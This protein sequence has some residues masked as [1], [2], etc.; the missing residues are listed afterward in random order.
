MLAA[1]ASNTID[2]SKYE[3]QD[4]CNFVIRMY[5]QVLG[6]K[7][8]SEGL[9]HWYNKLVNKE[10]EGANLVDGFVSSDEFKNKPLSTTEFLDIMYSAILDRKPDAQGSQNWSEVLSYGVSRKYISAQFVG[11]DEFNRLCA[12]YNI[13]QGHI[14]LSENRDKNLT[15][16]KFV[17]YFYQNCLNRQ[18]DTNGL[19]DWTGGLLSQSLTGTNIA[20]G[21]IFS[22]EF[23]NKGLNA[24]EFVKLLYQTILT[25]TADS[26]GLNDWTTRLDNGVSQHYVTANFILSQEF[27]DLCNNYGIRKGDPVIS[28]NRDKNYDMTSL[29]TYLYRNILKRS[30]A[31]TD[32]NDWTGRLLNHEFTATELANT[33]FSGDE[34]KSKNVSDTD[35]IKDLYVALLRREPSSVEIQDQLALIQNAGNDRQPLLNTVSE[36]KEYREIL[37]PMGIAP[38]QNG[39]FD[40]K[41]DTFYFSDKNKYIGWLWADGQRYYLNPTY[42]GARQT[43]G[44]Q[45]VD[46]WQFYFNDRG[47]LVQDVD[48]LIGPQDSYMIKVYKS[49][50]YAIVFAKDANGNYTIPVKSLL[51]SCGYATPTGGF[52]TPAKFRWLEML[53][54][55]QGQWCTQIVGDFLFHSV[56]YMTT[57]N[58][59]LY[60]DAMYNYL[61]TTASHGC[62]RLQAGDAKW[63]YDNCK[64]GT[65]VYIDGNENA[66][67]FDKPAFSPLPSWHTWDP[68]DPTAYY[69]CQQ[70]GCH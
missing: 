19:N 6:R 22:D 51:T 3:N 35:F 24:D 27:T 21:F 48:A 10:I 12:A 70:H 4:V 11:S 57:D 16:T 32:L 55:C 62:I 2:T 61:G 54:G 7:P 53:G 50:N 47:E 60:T 36:S 8:D 17:S 41:G 39:W 42:N 64:L 49:G 45:V 34:Y 23:Q 31:S 44:W 25:R 65:Y 9:D 14:D 29:V 66:G 1:P 59:T 28:E 38:I 43:N 46:G 5:D 40:I 63:M 69:L 20:D 33:F 56:P 18:G 13:S 26:D 37:F 52:Y 67:P 30:P 68:T 58:R 15:I